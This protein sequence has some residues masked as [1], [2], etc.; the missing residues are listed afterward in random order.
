M[1][2]PTSDRKKREMVDQSKN[3]KPEKEQTYKEKNGTT[4]VGDF[5][6]D[7]KG[8]A[9]DILDV[10][11]KLTGVDALSFIGEKL[12]ADP[13]VSKEDKEVAKAKIE[14]DIAEE[15]L[16]NKLKVE[17]EKNISRRWEADLK[18]DNQASKN[19]RPYT[20]GFL[21]ISFFII[22]VSDSAF[23]GFEVKPNFTSIYESLLLTAVNG[24]FV[25]REMGKSGKIR[26]TI[27]KAKDKIKNSFNQKS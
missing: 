21:V 23:Q 15:K 22:V 6:R 10:A 9:P 8:V 18:S 16:A 5:L 3:D 12:D 20:L 13:N 27:T 19:I 4:R 26:N 25:L 24:Y 1:K 7:V 11:G 14:A 2:N 17:Q